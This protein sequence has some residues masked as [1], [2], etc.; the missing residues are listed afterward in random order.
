VKD[1]LEAHIKNGY[2]ALKAQEFLEQAFLQ[3]GKVLALRFKMPRAKE[4][5]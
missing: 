1:C 2:I 5:F 3:K 4:F